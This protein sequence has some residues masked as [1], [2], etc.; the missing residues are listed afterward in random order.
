ML[1]DYMKLIYQELLHHHQEM[2]ESLEHEGKAYQIDYVKEMVS[3]IYYPIYKYSSCLNK[4]KYWLILDGCRQKSTFV[5][6]LWKPNG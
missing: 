6:S 5:A 4:S 3:T 2:E 1:P